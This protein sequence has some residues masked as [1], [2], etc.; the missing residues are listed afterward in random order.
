MLFSKENKFSVGRLSVCLLSVLLLNSSVAV[1]HICAAMDPR[2]EIDTQSL[3]TRSPSKGKVAGSS[4]KR[5]YRLRGQKSAHTNVHGT[6]HV[7]KSGDNLF[8]ILMRDYGLNNREAELFIEEIRRENN[9]YDIRRLKVGQKITIP[10]IRRNTDGSMKVDLVSDRGDLDSET[11]GQSF[12]LEPPVAAVSD[13]EISTKLRPVWD[14]LVP[15]DNEI[16]KPISIQ[17]PTF[18]L[19][20]DPQSYP[21]FTAMDKGR[22][23]VDV[24]AK[25]PSLVKALISEKD[26]SVRF[27]TEP[28]ADGKRIISSILASAGFYSVEENFK[29]EFG[30]D[31]TL[32]IRSDFKIEKKSDSVL[33]QDVV[34]LNAG[35]LALPASLGT[36]LEKEGFTLHEPFA[37]TQSSVPI[38]PRSLIQITSQRPVNILD[39]LLAALSI[40]SEKDCRLDIFTAG[41]DGIT[42]SVNA[43][44]YFE[45]NGQKTLVTHFDGDPVSYTLFRILET[46]GYKVVIL[47]QQDDFRN[48]TDKLLLRLNIKSVH[49]KHAFEK[50]PLGNYSLQMSGYRLEGAGLPLEGVFITNLE[51]DRVIRD[52]LTENGY[53]I[54][55]K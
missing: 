27:I 13:K 38:L 11:V 15:P 7:V 40:P 54:S 6:V 20:L 48:V 10:P 53:V 3:T 23:V 34:L 30:V 49:A 37:Q 12:R 14:K 22:I 42:L 24:D 51:I 25:V 47:D 8:K 16:L 46:R 55:V 50:D 36:F 29:L 21:M 31:P 17:T 26:P 18:S 9:I 45:R 44:R 28:G 35:R 33:N 41:T 2:F 4:T 52:V 5:P 43:E 39:S 1:R 32:S 19:T